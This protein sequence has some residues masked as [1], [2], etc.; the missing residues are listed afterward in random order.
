[1]NTSSKWVLLS[2]AMGTGWGR[3]VRELEGAGGS[4]ASAGH[5]APRLPLGPFCAPRKGDVGPAFPDNFAHVLLAAALASAGKAA[6]LL[7]AMPGKA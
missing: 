4:L 6:R 5:A 2:F 7:L 3:E 1:M